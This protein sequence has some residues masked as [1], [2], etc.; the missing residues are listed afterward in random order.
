MPTYE[1]DRG[2]LVEFERLTPEQQRLFREAVRKFVEDLGTRVIR[3]GLRVKRVQGRAGVWE[4]TRADDGRA[5]FAYGDSR[6][7]GDPHIIGLRIGTH[8]FVKNP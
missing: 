1:A 5:S 3:K 4:M 7:P 2:F 6:R 8:E